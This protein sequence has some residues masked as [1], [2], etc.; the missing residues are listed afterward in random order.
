[1]IKTIAL[2]IVSLSVLGAFI[3]FTPPQSPDFKIEVVQKSAF[4]TEGACMSRIL[5]K[6]PRITT[7]EGCRLG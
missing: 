3:S 7:K 5:D 1:M 4:K 6:A 2:G